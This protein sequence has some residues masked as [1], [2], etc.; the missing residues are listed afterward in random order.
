MEPVFDRV[1]G[2]QDAI[3]NIGAM[4]SAGQLPLALVGHF[5]GCDPVEAFLGLAST[6]HLIRSCE[7]T[8]FE[9]EVATS[10]IEANAAKG[11][12]VDMATFHI[13]RR[14]TLEAVVTA[15][16]G[17]IGVTQQTV[18]AIQEK[19]H[20][21][22]DRINEPDLSLSWRD[23]R[24]ARQIKTPEEKRAAHALIKADQEFIEKNAEVIVAEGSAD[25]DGDWLALL[26]QFDIGLLDEVRAAQGSGR[27][28]LCED[29]FLRTAAQTQF[30]VPGTWLQPVLM[31]ALKVGL[32]SLSAYMQA[33]VYLIDANVGF[34]SVSPDLLMQSVRGV[35]GHALPE[36]FEKLASR[37]GGKTADLASHSNVSLN[38]VVQLWSDES[39][40]Y[41]RRQAVA[42]RLME[43]LIRQQPK[44]RIR[45]VLQSWVAR[46]KQEG[47][48]NLA[49]YVVQ[50]VRGHF[51]E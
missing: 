38:A 24:I 4:Y 10:A 40:S 8:H 39:L 1:K 6:G 37:L 42:G 17:P 33:I 18:S 34:I 28:L 15:V 50:W 49:E 31:K 22:E 26:D 45:A 29:Q 3:E 35:K 36:S 7:G 43:M 14:L 47:L 30:S 32:L 25:V 16:C 2:R 48:E 23:G 13:V 12:V 44:D 41:T 21:L 27:L 46:A 9:R 5:V 11:C 19:L 20:E 51:I